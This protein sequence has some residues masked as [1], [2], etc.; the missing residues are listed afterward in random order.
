MNPTVP[1]VNKPI[2]SY[3]RHILIKLSNVT[4]KEFWKQKGKR[5]KWQRN[6]HK[7]IGGF[8]TETCQS[9]S[10]LD[11][12]FKIQQ[13]KKKTVHQE[14]HIHKMFMAY[15]IIII[16]M[17]QY[18]KYCYSFKI[19]LSF[20]SYER[21][22]HT[23]WLCNTLKKSYKQEENKDII[24]L[25]LN[26]ILCLCWFSLVAQTVKNLPAIQETRVWSLGWA[27]PLE[28]EMTTHSIFMPRE[29]HGQRSLVG[30]SPWGHKESD[31]TEQLT[32]THVLM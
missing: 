1:L 7:T 10:E 29:S 9:R 14:F 27:D 6:T 22:W 31:T 15:N 19:L 3:I 24:N 18:W 16:F 13:E 12:I 25:I 2:K 20:S 28:K 5:K 4:D 17:T 11:D 30:Y 26:I 23:V 21:E 8:S 32:H